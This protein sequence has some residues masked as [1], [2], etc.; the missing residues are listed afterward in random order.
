[1]MQLIQAS[2]GLRDRV[3]RLTCNGN[4]KLTS[5]YTGTTLTG[6]Q[7]RVQLQFLHQ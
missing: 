2:T 7:Q 3:L 1:M 5:T 6:R 4:G